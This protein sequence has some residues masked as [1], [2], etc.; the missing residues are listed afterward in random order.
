MAEV[1]RRVDK[2][3]WAAISGVLD[4]VGCSLTGPVLSPPECHTL[5]GLYSEDGRFTTRDRPV[6]SRRGWSA[7]PM[8]H[9]VSVLRSRRRH[10]LGLVFHDAR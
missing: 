1:A 3:D 9:G 7:A 10:A 5:S 8:R 6:P 2:L 4:E